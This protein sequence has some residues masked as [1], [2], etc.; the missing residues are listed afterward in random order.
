[1]NKIVEAKKMKFIYNGGITL[2][3]LL[4]CF[5]LDAVKVHR[6]SFGFLILFAF[7]AISTHFV[8]NDY[9]SACEKFEKKGK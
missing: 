9:L 2:I 3:S 6:A 1:M 7:S 5:V 8:Y 4:A